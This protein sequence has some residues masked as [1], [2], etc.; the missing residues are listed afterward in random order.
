MYCHVQST[1]R[2]EQQGT[3]N[4]H[5]QLP[6]K[7]KSQQQIQIQ[8]NFK[9]SVKSTFIMVRLKYAN[10]EKCTTGGREFHASFSAK[11]FLVQFL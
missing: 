4:R 1:K 2:A 9:N 3:D 5:Q 7:L 6:F 10:D 8:S 11:K